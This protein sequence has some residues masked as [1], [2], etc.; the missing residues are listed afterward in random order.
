MNCNQDETFKEQIAVEKMLYGDPPSFEYIAVQN[1]DFLVNIFG[2]YPKLRPHHL[3]NFVIFCS[4]YLEDAS[5]RKIVLKKVFIDCPTLIQRLY[6]IGCFTEKEIE[7]SL[8]FHR[9]KLLC[10]FFKNVIK[11]DYSSIMDDYNQEYYS[12]DTELES[13]IQFGFHQHSIEYCLKYDLFEEMG[14]IMINDPNKRE[15]KWSPFEWSENPKSLDFLSFSGFFGSLKCFRVLLL[16]GFFIDRQV[17][18]EVLCSGSKELFNIIF[19]LHKQ[20]SF[21]LHN[22]SKFGHLSI[23]EYLVNHKA[24]I[25]EKNN[26]NWTPLHLA[27][28]Y[29]HLSVV[30]YLVNQK[31]EINLKNNDV[32]YLYLVGLLFIWLLKMAV[33]VFLNI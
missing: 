13:L 4:H 31:A 23:V 21:Y 24:D 11:I 27:A 15:C 32:E 29:G 1:I 14:S 18:S 30:E 19:D 22:M 6:R 20:S 25:N 7:E 17:A 16:S 2:F 28:D 8:V 5:F 3:D 12:N 9:K 26:D 10:L 33:L